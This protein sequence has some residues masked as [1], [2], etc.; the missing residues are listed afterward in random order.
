[1]MRHLFALCFLSVLFGAGCDK[2]ATSAEHSIK[3]K[4][5]KEV[6][7]IFKRDLISHEQGV[8]KIAERLAE[9]YATP[10]PERGALLTKRLARIR[11]RPHGVS[12]LFASPLSFIVATDEKGVVLARYGATASIVS[13]NLAQGLPPL[14]KTLHEGT[15]QQ[16]IVQWTASAK[17]SVLWTFSAPIKRNDK[18]VGA[19]VL[20]IPLWRLDQQINHQLRI[21]YSKQQ[22][23]ILWV[24][25][26]YGAELHRFGTPPDLEL[27]VPKAGEREKRLRKAPLGYTGQVMQYGR[28]YAY[29]VFPLSE[30]D[31]KLG[32]VIFRSDPK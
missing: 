6:R 2:S 7:R 31:K 11:R 21:N 24:Y 30:F 5:I 10:M 20:G 12:E 27:M 15:P 3:K 14:Q 32:V 4:H 26:Y 25:L 1:M 19:A 22:N 13:T 16:A 9:F 29:G 17:P 8:K 18:M 28:W 23:L